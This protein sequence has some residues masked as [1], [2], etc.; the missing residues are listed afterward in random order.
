MPES[1]GPH[2]SQQHMLRCMCAVQSLYG[3][4]TALSFSSFAGVQS[5][6]PRDVIS[7]ADRE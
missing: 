6:V 1:L 3:T 5:E 7:A 2:V 4:E